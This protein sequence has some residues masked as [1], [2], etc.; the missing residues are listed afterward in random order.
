[1]NELIHFGD[2]TGGRQNQ[3][4][5]HDHAHAGRRDP[6]GVDLPRA[7]LSDEVAFVALAAARIEP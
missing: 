3:N 7:N 1:M 6:G 5:A 4:R 2:E